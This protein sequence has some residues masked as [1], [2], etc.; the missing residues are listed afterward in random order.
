MKVR[1]LAAFTAAA[2]LAVAT[3]GISADRAEAHRYWRGGPA[4]G[5]AAADVYRY[6]SPRRY[7]GEGRYRPYYY[8]PTRIYVDGLGYNRPP[9]YRRHP[10]Y[11]HFEHRYY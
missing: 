1:D 3:I 4:A 6:A 7:Y 8:G 5:P 11:R 10:Y 9:P 2:V